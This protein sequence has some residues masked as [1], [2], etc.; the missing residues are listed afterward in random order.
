MYYAAAAVVELV[1]QANLHRLPH[2]A[3]RGV[4]AERNDVAVR[5][6]MIA[7]IDEVL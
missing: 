2:G 7:D 6:K 1:R 5:P 3:A 4:G